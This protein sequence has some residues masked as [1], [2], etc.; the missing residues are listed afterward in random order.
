[1]TNKTNL[2]NTLPPLFPSPQLYHLLQQCRETVNGDYGKFITPYFSHYSGRGVIPLFQCRV[3]QETILQEFLQ[4]ES[5]SRVTVLHD[6]L[7]VSFHKVQSVKNSLLQCGSPTESQVLLETCSSMG[8][9]LHRSSG[10]C[11]NPAPAQ[12]HT[13]S[14]PPLRHP[15]T[16]SG[17]GFL[18]KL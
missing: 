11:Q 10:P 12:A 17:V 14:Q 3:T 5:F 13:A 9:S 4:H 18:H 15:P 6:L 1:M 8:S 16:C 2:K 7:W